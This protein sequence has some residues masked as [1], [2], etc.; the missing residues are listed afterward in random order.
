MSVVFAKSGFL[1]NFVFFDVRFTFCLGIPALRI[2]HWNIL[3]NFQ[4]LLLFFGS[5]SLFLVQLLY[6]PLYN[7]CSPFSFILIDYFFV[8]FLNALF[9]LGSKTYLCIINFIEYLADSLTQLIYFNVFQI[10]WLMNFG[11]W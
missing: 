8:S 4:I 6:I 3:D 9:L 2:F 1:R 11:C 5:T 7:I 10:W